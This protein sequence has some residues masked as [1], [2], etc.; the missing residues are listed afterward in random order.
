MQNRNGRGR[1]A[2]MLRGHVEPVARL[3]TFRSQ[4]TLRTLTLTQSSTL[5]TPHLRQC[6]RRFEHVK[7]PKQT[8]NVQNM[9]WTFLTFFLFGCEV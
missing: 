4:V 1:T 6:R 2:P 9:F 3:R 5:P 7:L 8:S